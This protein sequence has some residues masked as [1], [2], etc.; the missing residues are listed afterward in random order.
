MKHLKKLNRY[1][2]FFKNRKNLRERIWQ[3]KKIYQSVFSQ[4]PI[5]S[6][7]KRMTYLLL[8]RQKIMRIKILIIK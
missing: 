6:K 5:R 7:K 3:N 1:T 8:S 4:Q 2:K